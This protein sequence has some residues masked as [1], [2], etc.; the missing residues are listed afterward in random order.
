MN[1]ILA[2]AGF[3]LLALLFI[4]RN[5]VKFQQL[6]ST[7]AQQDPEVPSEAVASIETPATAPEQ[8]PFDMPEE[9]SI[10]FMPSSDSGENDFRPVAPSMDQKQPLPTETVDGSDKAIHQLFEWVN[11]IHT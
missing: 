8:P 6:S 9:S 10:P 3:V 11:P 4:E 7:L 5:K 2:I 1:P